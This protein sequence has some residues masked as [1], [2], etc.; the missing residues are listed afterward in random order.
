MT[1]VRT[2]V[3]REFA[4]TEF[5]RAAFSEQDGE[6]MLAAVRGYATVEF[7]SPSTRWKWRLRA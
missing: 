7:P 3:L 2:I 4:A 6:Q 5:D 1:T